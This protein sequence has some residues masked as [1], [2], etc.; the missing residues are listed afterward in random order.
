[1]K[2]N[3]FNNLA[4]FELTSDEMNKTQGGFVFL[5]FTLGA[6]AVNLA[7]GGSVVTIFGGGI[8]NGWDSYDAK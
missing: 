3:E 4:V 5:L 7:A 2:L 1:M 8:K 6:S